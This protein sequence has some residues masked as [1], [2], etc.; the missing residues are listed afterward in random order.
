MKAIIFDLDGTLWDSTEVVADAWNQAIHETTN[1]DLKV[2]ADQLKGL[3]GRPLRDIVDNV[4]PMFD[5]NQKKNIEQ[6]L[7]HFEHDLLRQNTCPLYPS[8][9][10]VL[11]SLSQ[12]HK[13]FIVSNC[14]AGYIEIFLEKTGLG[15]YITDFT[16]PGET[17]LLKGDNIKLIIERNHL[18][19]AI[20]VGDTQG[21]ADA[22]K[23]AGI[24]IIYAS[25]GFGLVKE[26][27]YVISQFS[28]LL[29]FDF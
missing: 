9:P 27:D 6:S 7:Y 5:E 22:C 21:D 17:G 8:V 14:Q 3:F 25:Y 23:I 20:Y 29:T 2:T 10:E 18:D 28:D 15:N 19:S 16:C 11:S 4:F 26:P 1:L 24:P 13:L 12:T